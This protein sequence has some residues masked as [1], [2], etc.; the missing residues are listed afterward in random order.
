MSIKSDK[1]FLIPPIVN[2][3]IIAK[4]RDIS[5]NGELNL[6]CKLRACRRALSFWKKEGYSMPNIWFKCWRKVWSVFNPKVT[7]VSLLRIRSRKSSLRFT[8]MTRKGEINSKFFH[9]SVKANIIRIRLS[10]L[11]DPNGVKQCSDAAKRELVVEY[12]QN[13]LNLQIQ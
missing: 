11:F 3:E 1:R 2:D 8:E 12:F 10:K 6:S 5:A 13:F 4:R 9:E 7:R